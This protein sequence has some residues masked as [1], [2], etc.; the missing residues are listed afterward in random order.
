MT[1]AA[2]PAGGEVSAGDD[3]P[4]PVRAAAGGWRVVAGQE[5][6]D[7]WFSGR[8]PVL[9]FGLSVLLSVVTYLAASNQ[10]LNFL[11]QREAVNLALQIAVVVGV[12]VTLV[13]SAD[14][15][16]GDRDRGTLESLLLSPVSRRAIVTGKLAAALSLWLA[17]YLVSVPYVWVLARGVSIAR[18][19]LLL[20]LLVG[21]LLA[22]GLAMLG[23]LISAA[24]SSNRMSVSVSLF[25]LI[26]LFAPT[27]LPERPQ[28][29]FGAAL[30]RANPVDAAMHYVEA[31]LVQGHGWTR[32]L[33]YLVSPL[34]LAVLAGGALLLAGSRVIRVHPWVS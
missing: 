1:A 19:T 22:I 3:D 21:T 24:S 32:D 2:D 12:L 10:A 31:V 26:A 7:L 25:V 4:G 15:I 27:Q 29:W 17:T 5:C 13:A 18:Q 6:R 20:G 16:S 8:A 34:L 33:S 30:D 9:L 14:A 23:L 11:E 28:G